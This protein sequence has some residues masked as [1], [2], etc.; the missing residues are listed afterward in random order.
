[1]ENKSILHNHILDDRME[2]YANKL[3]KD[4]E[5][6]KQWLDEFNDVIRNARLGWNW[7]PSGIAPGGHDFGSKRL[8]QYSLS[9]SIAGAIYELVEY[10]IEKTDEA[11]L[12]S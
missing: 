12:Q 4:D 8:H 9:K 2:Y 5:F 11:D 1:M 3:P 6:I 10:M 7:T